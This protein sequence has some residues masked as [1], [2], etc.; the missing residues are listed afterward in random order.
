MDSRHLANGTTPGTPNPEKPVKT[1]LLF[2]LAV[3]AIPGN[4]YAS[5]VDRFL[6]SKYLVDWKAEAAKHHAQRDAVGGSVFSK[7]FAF[8]VGCA[9]L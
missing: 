3:R 9:L 7:S 6:K 8:V 5:P 2:F 4:W 1:N